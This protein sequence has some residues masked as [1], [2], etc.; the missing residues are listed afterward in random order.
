MILLVELHD[1]SLVQENQRSL[2]IPTHFYPA[3]RSFVGMATVIGGFGFN[4]VN[5]LSCS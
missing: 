1:C 4:L 3:K 5:W 2:G